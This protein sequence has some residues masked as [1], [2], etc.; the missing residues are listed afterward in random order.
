[1]TGPI[2][3]NNYE[4]WLLD[5]AEGQL[6]ADRVAELKAFLAAHPQ[7][8]LDLN[9]VEL[10][11]LETETI[12]FDNRNAL[13]KD[14]ENLEDTALL[15]YLEGLG[16]AAERAAFEQQLQHN[17]NLQAAL[18]LYSK[19][20]LKPDANV[21]LPG[22]HTLHKNEADLVLNNLPLLYTEGLLNAA[23]RADFE[24]TMAANTALRQDVLLLQKTKLQADNTIY[25]PNKQALK[26]E[27]LLIGLFSYRNM[28]RV[29]AALLLLVGLYGVLLYVKPTHTVEV[30]EKPAGKV[31]P[32][33]LP[34]ELAAPSNTL[35]SPKVLPPAQQQIQSKETQGG[36]P[37][38]LAAQSSN[39]RQ[40]P[41]R[42]VP[43]NQ[44]VHSAP[45]TL[46]AH[47]V[48]K[49][50]PAAGSNSLALVAT[51]SAAIAQATTNLAPTTLKPLETGNAALAQTAAMGVGNALAE[52][53]TYKTVEQ[54]ALENDSDTDAETGA[55][56][57]T[58]FWQR[59]VNLAKRANTFGVK[60]LESEEG[61]NKSYSISFRGFSVEKR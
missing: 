53:I 41:A 55:V 28:A 44:L 9:D 37:L 2:H 61:S 16:S 1:M 21:V 29:A 30:A 24:N 13:K 19:T 5:Y 27:A 58:G 40:Q 4:A 8:G 10:P 56:Q 26:K 51:P 15:H 48:V 3:I 59:A 7:L 45:D 25:F 12:A 34:A 22:K 49:P 23:E 39:R 50:H 46:V 32:A 35:A 11:Y 38:Q 17:A 18:A 42:T 52:H 31:P 47:E 57:K 33:A 60:D 36:E 6:D 43:N 14:A 20:I 54:L